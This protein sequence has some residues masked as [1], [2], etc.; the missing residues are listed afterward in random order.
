MRCKGVPL[1]F[2]GSIK[3]HMESKTKH[4]SKTTVKSFTGSAVKTAGA[5]TMNMKGTT[6]EETW[7]APSGIFLKSCYKMTSTHVNGLTERM[8]S[9]KEMESCVLWHKT[10]SYKSG[11]ATQIIDM[12]F[13]RGER[14]GPA[15]LD[16]SGELVSKAPMRFSPSE[17]TRNA[18]TASVNACAYRTLHDLDTKNLGVRVFA[19]LCLQTMMHAVTQEFLAVVGRYPLMKHAQHLQ[20]A[21]VM[22]QDVGRRGRAALQEEFTL[23]LGPFALHKQADYLE[24]AGNGGAVRLGVGTKTQ[25]GAGTEI[26]RTGVHA[27][28]RDPCTFGLTGL[29]GFVGRSSEQTQ[30]KSADGTEQYSSDKVRDGSSVKVDILG[31]EI[32]EAGLSFQE[33]SQCVKHTDGQL[34]IVDN[35]S[36]GNVYHFSSRLGDGSLAY[37]NLAQQTQKVCQSGCH[38]QAESYT[39]EYYGVRLKAGSIDTSVSLKTTKVEA[40]QASSVFGI[41][42][43]QDVQSYQRNSRSMTHTHENLLYKTSTQGEGRMP[44]F[45]KGVE[46]TGD[47][48]AATIRPSVHS[49]MALASVVSTIVDEAMEHKTL[50]IDSIRKALRTGSEGFVVSVLSVRLGPAAARAAVSLALEAKVTVVDLV[51]EGRSL[52]SDAKS[53]TAKAIPGQ[54]VLEEFGFAAAAA[55][56]TLAPPALAVG[57]QAGPAMWKWWNG[58]MTRARLQYA[59][60]EAAVMSAATFAGATAGQVLGSP[61]GPGASFLCGVVGCRLGGAMANSQKVKRIMRWCTGMSTD[62]ER[63]YYGVSSSEAA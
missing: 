7:T 56:H 29:T 2:K 8:T 22:L 17:V 9:T 30:S 41:T 19:E 16:S 20:Q 27:H 58:S 50:N 1:E 26:Q 14:K 38:S 42:Y 11:T 28:Y 61:L 34:E 45:Q 53:K 4:G 25:Q 47:P 63:E 52:A 40:S 48:P 54:R 59:T 55:S 35:S 5:E 32:A 62:E 57:L 39:A 18:I 60:S 43:S 33:K 12:P 36:K 51:T 6:K 15:R 3:D 44:W 13:V 21:M 46:F 24:V 23:P 37:G 10:T 49:E 31:V